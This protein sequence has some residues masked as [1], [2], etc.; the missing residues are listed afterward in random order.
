MFL[1][2]TTIQTMTVGA[3]AVELLS[4]ISDAVQKCQ[5]QEEEDNKSA[6][7][8]NQDEE[9]CTKG[10]ISPMQCRIVNDLS[11]EETDG[12]VNEMSEEPEQSFIHPFILEKWN[13]FSLG[14]G[15]GKV[16]EQQAV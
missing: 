7:L 11:Q 5:G 10:T 8:I 14:S 16:E 9:E 4:R 1:S 13:C 3:A 6:Y 12:D 2:T 15:C